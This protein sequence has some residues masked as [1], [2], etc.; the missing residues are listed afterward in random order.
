MLGEAFAQALLGFST[1]SLVWV[2]RMLDITQQSVLSFI[3]GVRNMRWFLLSTLIAFMVFI[4]LSNYQS[5]MMMSVDI[6]YECFW[7]PFA[8]VFN[9]YIL[10]MPF[11][12]FLDQMI[13][14]V[15]NNWLLLIRDEVAKQIS[16]LAPNAHF[17]SVAETVSDIRALSSAAYDALFDTTP[18]T[19]AGMQTNR[20]TVDAVTQVLSG[21]LSAIQLFGDAALN[22]I[23]QIGTASVF[24][25]DSDFCRYQTQMLN[26]FGNSSGNYPCLFMTYGVD[27]IVDWCATNQSNNLLGEALLAVADA[28]NAVITP[29]AT[30]PTMTCTMT[31]QSEPTDVITNL[32]Y[33]INELFSAIL[34][35]P[36]WLIMAAIDNGIH[37]GNCANFG[38][39]SQIVYFL[40]QWGVDVLDALNDLLQLISYCYA[41]NFFVWLFQNMM[42][43]IYNIINEF[44][45]MI[46]C[47]ETSFPC[48]TNGDSPV[49]P[50][51]SVEAD[52]YPVIQQFLCVANNATTAANLGVFFGFL[53]NDLLEPI[54]TV[55]CTLITGIDDITQDI[56]GGIECVAGACLDEAL[57][58]VASGIG[59]CNPSGSY[60][61]FAEYGQ[62]VPKCFQASSEGMD[63][64]NTFTD[65]ELCPTNGYLCGPSGTLP[66]MNPSC[67]CMSENNYQHMLCHFVGNQ[68]DEKQEL[69][70][71]E[72]YD[73]TVYVGHYNGYSECGAHNGPTHGPY[74]G[75][76]DCHQWGEE[77]YDHILQ[78]C[79]VNPDGTPL[80]CNG[81]T[82][83]CMDPSYV[84]VEGGNYYD[85]DESK[86]RN[87]GQPSN[88]LNQIERDVS[89][90]M[91]NLKD[92]IATRKEKAIADR[93]LKIS[94]ANSSHNFVYD[95][96]MPYN[97]TT[98][99]VVLDNLWRSTLASS[100]ISNQT[101][102]GNMVYQMHPKNV[103]AS[104]WMQYSVYQTCLHTIMQFHVNALYG[105]QQLS[106]TNNS[107]NQQQKRL[108]RRQNTNTTSRAISLFG[109]YLDTS[110]IPH[111]LYA[112]AKNTGS[113]VQ[114][115]VNAVTGSV[116]FTM[117]RQMLKDVKHTQ[118]KMPLPDDHVMLQQKKIGGGSGSSKEVMIVTDSQ[119]S[120]TSNRDDWL[121]LRR[122][123]DFAEVRREVENI[124][125]TW[126]NSMVA[127]FRYGNASY[128]V[129]PNPYYRP[130]SIYTLQKLA[131]QQPV[132]APEVQAV[133]QVVQDKIPQYMEL[134]NS[135]FNIL[136]KYYSF[137]YW[138]WYQRL[139]LFRRI[140]S[141][142]GVP[143]KDLIDWFRGKNGYLAAEGFVSLEQYEKTMD[144]KY[145]KTES[146]L[147]RMAYGDYDVRQ[148]R[149]YCPFL[150][151][152]SFDNV[153]FPDF[154]PAFDL[155]RSHYHRRLLDPRKSVPIGRH[156]RDPLLYMN[157]TGDMQQIRS[158]L[159]LVESH[160][161]VMFTNDTFNFNNWILELWDS[162][163]HLIFS[164]GAPS[165]KEA[166]DTLIAKV[167]RF[168]YTNWF[169]SNV[170]NWFATLV[171]CAIPDNYDGTTVYN[172]FCF[173]LIPEG[174][175]AFFTLAPNGYLP[176]QIPWPAGLIEQNCVT[177]VTGN[178]RPFHF[179]LPD[180][181]GANNTVMPLCGGS[182]NCDYCQRTY[183]Q[184]R[185]IG[186]QDF[187]DSTMFMLGSMS[188][189]FAYIF[190]G[191]LSG[192]AM[193][194]FA[195]GML[196]AAA[197]IGLMNGIM[198][199]IVYIF[200]TTFLFW[201]V[202]AT[203][204]SFSFGFITLFIYVATVV[205][206]GVVSPTLLL[207]FFTKT[208]IATLPFFAYI[209]VWFALAIVPVAPATT[210]FNI[211]GWLAGAVQT[212]LYGLFFVP[213]STVDMIVTRIDR[214]NYNGGPIPSE[215]I[216]CFFMTVSDTGLLA[217]VLFLAF[218]ILD[219]LFRAAFTTFVTLI[220]FCSVGAQ[221]VRNVRAS[222]VEELIKI[223]PERMEQVK[224]EMLAKWKQHTGTLRGF[225][226]ILRTA[227]IQG[228]LN[229]RRDEITDKFIDDLL[230]TTDTLRDIER[231]ARGEE[232]DDGG[233]HLM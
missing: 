55:I 109:K 65:G 18:F 17:I 85:S 112:V 212:L 209:V 54:A 172:P 195:N 119:V 233:L 22:L 218:Y 8:Y 95:P 32:A 142:G 154:M 118:S 56:I 68:G 76:E 87:A 23:F 25:Q 51:C 26:E 14:P 33:V 190:A 126:A 222:S 162:F 152:S 207:S 166:V 200:V 203:Y 64:Y 52:L 12:R 173:P 167:E 178:P 137:E 83:V 208:G 170:N 103:N 113:T 156:S 102:C 150:L 100:N 189:F 42:A 135:V 120:V 191:G 57:C 138:P 39:S 21:L 185:D 27:G 160:T 94:Y 29:F 216:F 136:N 16:D 40:S 140:Y 217:L 61:G 5:E 141:G 146:T 168:N 46:D 28:I 44:T 123:E 148:P 198:T 147:L 1:E 184:C 179:S 13:L 155:V 116:Y 37:N 90:Q 204:T 130:V 7:Y 151:C 183:Y 227:H 194:N 186:F 96:S 75:G 31:G 220:A 93:D 63:E 211:T 175:F 81:V 82:R 60:C 199:M 163:V 20:V 79:A 176:M 24:G 92:R 36:G 45:V 165:V 196:L 182:W 106:S 86:K 58:S 105:Q 193:V 171:Q 10:Y 111:I 229:P 181:C 206:L 132:V 131:E 72:A 228:T 192:T 187:F 121:D 35:R 122:V 6:V 149:T 177:P 41:D 50:S 139:H 99:G 180:A 125:L 128:A 158:E 205:G 101:F 15:L 43:W 77:S 124:F 110:S 188:Q 19:N 224:Q 49:C 134:G 70:C 214:F 230:A 97:D 69:E 174:M 104:N 4:V 89:A 34:K 98:I 115:A 213:T 74:Y 197:I 3:Q 221:F 38:D 71:Q 2:W 145:T 232:D 9:T 80:V 161:G 153:S 30:I 226:K 169:E 202:A 66:A 129:V 78:S 114:N 84:P 108:A 215:D 210:A 107:T 53:A 91:K 117:T 143:P 201:S 59:L 73:E 223:Q 225:S 48:Y 47:F 144:E 157:I 219:F 11:N 159:S 164:R 133:A 67:Q 127:Q 62:C 88:L 231:D